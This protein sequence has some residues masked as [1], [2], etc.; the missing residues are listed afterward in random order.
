MTGSK[1]RDQ[2]KHPRIDSRFQIRSGVDPGDLLEM[3]SLNL[4][5][6]GV[7]CSTA[8]HVPVMTKLLLTLHLPAVPGLAPPSP[9]GIQTEAVVVRVE[10][11]PDGKGE[12]YNLALFFSQMA[13]K[14]R[15]RLAEFLDLERKSKE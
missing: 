15:V 8:R 6:E 7:Y 10:P 1:G 12:R 3:E 5:L 2:R 14:D 4:S 9:E 13:K 11:D